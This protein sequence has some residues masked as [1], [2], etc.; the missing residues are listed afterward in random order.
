M[1]I[2]IGPLGKPLQSYL[3]FINWSDGTE[4]QLEGFVDRQI[5]EV[6]RVR[7][8]R[9]QFTIDKELTPPPPPSHTTETPPPSPSPR[10]SLA[11]PSPHPASPTPRRSAPPP[12]PSPQL[13]ILE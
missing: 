12:A 11:P 4:G 10:P 9:G 8:L 6:I 5:A 7:H 2:R 3:V 13:R 1:S